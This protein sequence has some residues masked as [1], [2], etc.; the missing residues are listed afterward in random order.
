MKKFIIMASILLS[1]CLALCGCDSDSVGDGAADLSSGEVTISDSQSDEY[2]QAIAEKYEAY[3]GSDNLSEAAIEMA[4]GVLSEQGVIDDYCDEYGVFT[5]SYADAKAIAKCYIAE[6]TLLSENDVRYGVSG[7]LPKI[8]LKQL[9]KQA[10]NG[11]TVVTYGR[12][13]EDGNWLFPAEYTFCNK[14]IDNPPEL[15]ADEFAAEKEYPVIYN[16]ATLSDIEQAIQLYSDN[17]YANLVEARE[18]VLSTPEDILEMCD[19][20]NSGAYNELHAKYTLSADIDMAGITMAPIGSYSPPILPYDK[21]LPSAG[22]FCGSL[23][24]NGYAIKNITIYSPPEAEPNSGVK[25][26]FFDTLNQA[27]IENLTLENASILVSEGNDTVVS[28]GI[29]AASAYSSKINYCNVS[30]RVFG[31]SGVGGLIGEVARPI[32]SVE[33]PEVT[34]IIGCTSKAEVTAGEFVGGL[35]GI[36]NYCYIGN[37]FSSGAVE[38]NGEYLKPDI[39]D[40]LPMAAGG[41]VGS[42]T[43]ATINSCGSDTVVKTAT[44]ASCVGMFVGLNEGEIVQS[45]YNSENGDWKGAGDY[46]EELYT[47]ELEPLS[48][49]EYAEK[50]V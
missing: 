50:I 43:N 44:T 26:G 9:D 29:L 37:S 11:Y 32:S 34:G 31:T 6:E 38:I 24:G 42:N 23:D 30:G 45:F 36:A 41:F 12:F 15:I 1:A 7:E 47:T 4:I 10:S 20:V 17:G 13:T 14:T 3:Y 16:V 5:M 2:Y 21:R 18:Y 49:S 19:R 22:G 25:C 40:R 8:S 27:V 33:Y 35:V 46:V 28:S 48:K 39:N